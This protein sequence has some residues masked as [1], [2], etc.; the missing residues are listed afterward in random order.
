MVTKY[1]KRISGPLLDRIDIHIEVPR[2]DYEKLSG[3]R[4]GESSQTIRVRVQAARNIQNRRFSK[5]SSSDIV[6]NADM[7]VGEVRQFCKLQDEGQSLMRV[8]M[9]QLNLSARAYHRIL[10]LARTI[11]DLAGSEEIQ[12]THL[13]EALQYRPK[14]MMG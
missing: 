6:C 7:R 11:A 9:T 12:S 10:K 14:L 4:V 8:A 2:V 5:N 1:Q 3:D 13:A